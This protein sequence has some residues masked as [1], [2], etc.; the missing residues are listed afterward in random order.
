MIE[1]EIC[2]LSV[3][4]NFIEFIISDFP[5]LSKDNINLIL[6]NSKVNSFSLYNPKD[7]IYVITDI[8]LI[9]NDIIILYVDAN[10]LISDSLIIAF[11]DTFINN[12]VSF[13]ILFDSMPSGIY[14][15]SLQKINDLYVLGQS[16]SDFVYC[17]NIDLKDSTV[18]II[19]STLDFT[20]IDITLYSDKD[21][22]KYMPNGKYRIKYKYKK[23]S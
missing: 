4:H 12:N 21:N 13:P 22:L 6:N 1:S 8:F 14:N 18:E 11:G 15:L 20:T 3:G 5:K 16:S 10:N 2:I 7:N 17:N 19:D 23:R 9:Q